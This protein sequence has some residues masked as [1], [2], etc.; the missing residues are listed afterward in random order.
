MITIN[1]ITTIFWWSRKSGWLV[2]RRTRKT[3]VVT[4]TTLQLQYNT[5]FTY[6]YSGSIRAG[7]FGFRFL[8][9]FVIRRSHHTERNFDLFS[10][11][12]RR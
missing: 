4:Q 7:A 3:H 6:T 10:V 2:R 8:V 1:S 11:I 12:I 5:Y 9:I